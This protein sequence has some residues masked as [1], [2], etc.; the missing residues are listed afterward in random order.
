MGLCM[1]AQLE[2]DFV[3]HATWSGTC[4]ARPSA[5]GHVVLHAR[6][7]RGLRAQ[8]E[9]DLQCPNGMGL[10]VACP[11]VMGLAR[12]KAM[13]LVVLHARMEWDLVCLTSH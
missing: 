1:H 11:N 9:W 6:M 13:G 4:I 2:R 12:P 10:R 5:M 7:E 3:L 8:M